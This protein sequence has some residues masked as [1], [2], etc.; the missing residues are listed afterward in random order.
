MHYLLLIFKYGPQMFL[1]YIRISWS[2][3]F[4]IRFLFLWI[5]HI[6][7]II[8]WRRLQTQ[9]SKFCRRIEKEFV[10]HTPFGIFLWKNIN[11]WMVLHPFYEPGVRGVIESNAKKFKKDSNKIFIDIGAHTGRYVIELVKNYWYTSYAFEPNLPT[12]EVL[13]INTILSHLEDKVFLYNLGLSDKAG[14]YSFETMPENDWSSRIVT[15]EKNSKKMKNISTIVCDT[16]DNVLSKDVMLNTRLILIDVEGFEFSVVSGMKTF[17]KGIRDCDVVIELLPE[18]LDR[19][20]TMEFMKD[21]GFTM[22]RLDK[23]NYCFTK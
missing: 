19:E 20:N 14:E 9:Y 7:D 8:S 23:V 18:T 22:N 5:F 17:L 2:I 11:Q 4:M 6:I 12:Y 3:D 21:L 10:F 16:W 1:Y 15:G 13:K